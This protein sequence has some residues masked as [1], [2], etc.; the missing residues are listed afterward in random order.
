[1][2]NPGYIAL[3]RLGGQQRNV[4]TMANNIANAGTPGFK[5]GRLVFEDFVFDR[6]GSR[7][8]GAREVAFSV[9]RG[10]YRDPTAGPLNR[11]DNPLDLAL[12]GDGFFTIDTPRGER[13]T[14]SGRFTIA[15]DGRV[16]TSEGYTL[17]N[18]ENRPITVS[19]QDTRLTVAADGTVES[20]NGPLGRIRIV[21]FEDQNR[22]RPEGEVLFAADGIDP[23][24]AA[25]PKVMQGMIEDSNVQ[26]ILEMT[27]LMT[28]LREF[29]FVSQFVERE[30][31]RLQNAVER[32]SRRRSQ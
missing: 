29:Q 23:Q 11:T 2:D 21:T 3:S 19:Q 20:E 30:G 31:E 13:F 26:P 1:M 16:T 28:E 18:I 14:R 32:L 25:A 5:A 27:R 17:M 15:P 9:D 6:G 7:R 12:S 10:S 4:D 24:P 22:L 8:P